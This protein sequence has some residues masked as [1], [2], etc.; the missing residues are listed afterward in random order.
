DHGRFDSLDFSCMAVYGSDYVVMRPKLAGKRLDLITAF[1]NQDEVHILRAVEPTL[2]IR[3]H[4]TTCDSDLVEEDYTRCM[5]SKRE[6]IAAKDQLAR[7][8]FHEE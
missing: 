5:A 8:L 6:N 1:M 4:Q 7:L 3:Y 2:R